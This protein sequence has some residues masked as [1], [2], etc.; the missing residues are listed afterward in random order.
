MFLLFFF[1]ADDVIKA[2]ND[3]SLCKLDVYVKN[4]TTVAGSV[5]LRKSNQNVGN[6]TFNSLI[7]VVYKMVLMFD[8]SSKVQN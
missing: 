2:E 6:D 3:V 5:G 7:R 4:R 8:T 1:T